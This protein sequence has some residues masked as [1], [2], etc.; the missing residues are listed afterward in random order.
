MTPGPRTAGVVAVTMGEPAGI[1]AEIALKAWASRQAAVPS[2]ALLG[3][4]EHAAALSTRLGLGVPVQAIGAPEEAA[5]VFPD[6]LPVVPV[7]LAAPVAPGHPSPANARPVI[8]A[9]DLAVEYAL[10][11]R[12]AALV[13]SPIQKESLY[14]VGFDYPGHTE[15]LA[16]LAGGRAIPVMM[17]VCPGLRAVPVLV[18]LS[19][20]DAIRTLTREAIV[21]C[22]VITEEALRIDFGVARPRLAVAALNPHAG[23]GGAMGREEIDIIDPAVATLRERGIDVIGPAPADSLFHTAARARYDAA[24]C[25]HHDQALIPIKTIDFDNG[26]NITLGLPF[27]RTSP[28]HGT[29]LAIAGRGEANPASLIAALKAAADIAGRRRA[30]ALPATG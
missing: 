28:D 30:L 3:D 22:G 5:G 10:S 26:V 13:T 25:M 16:E 4:P 2:F 29:A 8:A 1:G 14:G 18:H 20:R 9:I 24:L 15:Y 21:T 19:L 7:P 6:A 11:G 27:V 12:V 17:L 23:E